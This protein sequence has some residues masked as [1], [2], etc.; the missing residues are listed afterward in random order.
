MDPSQ[1]PAPTR[2]RPALHRRPANEWFVLPQLT[3][4]PGALHPSH[5]CLTTVLQ[6]QDARKSA[7]RHPPPVPHR[8]STAHNPL[9]P[10]P[11]NRRSLLGRI[12]P[13]HSGHFAQNFFHSRL[14]FPLLAAT[15]L[16][17]EEQ[18]PCAKNHVD[19]IPTSA[20][21][22]RSPSEPN[23]GAGHHR[24][25]PVAVHLPD[26]LPAPHGPTLAPPAAPLLPSLYP[27][28]A[29]CKSA[30]VVACRTSPAGVSF[31]L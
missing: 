10:R 8:R 5:I 19:K 13:C 31:S 21:G 28:F 3:Q 27:W 26:I 11:Q 4:P 16:D 2:L 22:N 17:R 15:I 6:P 14:H 12:I 24:H 18:S 25:P 29:P 9:L 20:A 30:P 23:R 1:L 7:A